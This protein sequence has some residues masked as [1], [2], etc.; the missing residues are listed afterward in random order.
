MGGKNKKMAKWCYVKVKTDINEFINFI[1]L[2]FWGFG[3]LG[4]WGRSRWWEIVA[5][6][7]E[8]MVRVCSSLWPLPSV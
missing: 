2:G 1:T 8:W 5:A 4:F 6:S 3:V 7:E